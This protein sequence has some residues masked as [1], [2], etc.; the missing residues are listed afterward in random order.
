MNLWFY[1]F[2]FKKSSINPRS[3][4]PKS[5]LN[6]KFSRGLCPLDPHRGPKVGPWT[7]PVTRS[8]R[9]ARYAAMV[10]RA[11]LIFLPRPVWEPSPPLLSLNNFHQKMTQ[12]RSQ[13]GRGRG[14]Q[15]LC[16]PLLPPK[17]NYILYRGLMES[18]H[19]ESQSAP[20]S[21]LSPPCPLILKSWATPL[22]NDL[23][24]PIFVW[25]GDLL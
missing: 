12:W 4:T 17:W 21:P 19:F 2:C 15:K 16:P 23:L 14:R 22:I 5:A 10:K 7:P 3:P 6:P 11:A 9:L 20:C 13:G 25:K 1:D 18:H 8:S 24:Y